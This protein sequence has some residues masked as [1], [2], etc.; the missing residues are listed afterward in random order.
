M[1]VYYST[2]SSNFITVKSQGG[3]APLRPPLNEALMYVY[4]YTCNLVQCT[5]IERE[6]VEVEPS[7]QLFPSIVAEGQHVILT[8]VPAHTHGEQHNTDAILVI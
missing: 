2:V 7:Q 1:G 5:I 4:T 8:Q 3:N 6:L